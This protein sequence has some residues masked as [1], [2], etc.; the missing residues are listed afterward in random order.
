[1]EQ[2]SSS[3][4]F[5]MEDHKYQKLQIGGDDQSL[6]STDAAVVG[7][8]NHSS[9]VVKVT[10]KMGNSTLI[11]ITALVA[12]TLGITIGVLIGWFS[13]Q[14]QFPDS[15]AY[16]IWQKALE[17][18]DETVRQMIQEELKAENIRENLR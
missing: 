18:E 8:S 9:A 1:M 3:T 12:A 11:V 2:A 5:A 13:S 14:A 16:E 17:G 10:T 15:E 6:N 4:P 7:N